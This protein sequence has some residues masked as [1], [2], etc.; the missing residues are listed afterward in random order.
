MERPSSSAP[1]ASPP[2]AGHPVTRAAS[3][4]A[5]G[6]AVAPATGKRRF[7]LFGWKTGLLLLAASLGLAYTARHEL[8]SIARASSVR[9]DP[10]PASDNEIGPTRH[11]FAVGFVDGP[12][13]VASLYP[14]QAGRVESVAVKEGEKVKKG[15]TLLVLDKVTA[16]SQVDKAEAA[17][18]AAQI[19]LDQ[20]GQLNEQ[21]AAKIEAQNAIIAAKESQVKAARSRLTDVEGLLKKNLIRQEEVQ[22]A[23]QALS[24]MESSVEAEKAKLRLL[25]LDKPSQDID[26]A[27]QEVKIRA[28]DLRDAKFALEQRTLLAPTDGV[29]LRVQT[30]V[31]EVL[32]PNP[33]QAAILFLPT[34]KRIIRAELE[35]EFAGKV[36]MSQPVTIEDDSTAKGSWKGKVSHIS[37][38]FTNRR[39]IIPEPLQLNDVRTLEVI[40]EL[41]GSPTNLRIGQ[42]MR[43]KFD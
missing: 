33:R 14:L 10:A 22:Q 8:A 41:E 27:R 2:G 19:Q 3:P 24:A 36:R 7:S 32:G 40:I 38:W 17:L 12:N 6:H 25:K 11:P 42:R 13:G 4:S 26:R 37:D 18:K 34:G 1:P 20:A 35:Q 29:I 23:R 15:A 5:N 21:R 9:A 31:G 39:S 28:A 30:V 43:V 16:Q